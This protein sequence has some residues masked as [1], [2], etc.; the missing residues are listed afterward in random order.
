MRVQHGAGHSGLDALRA[1]LAQVIAN[2]VPGLAS[3]GPA[4]GSGPSSPPWAYS[5]AADVRADTPKGTTGRAT[6]AKTAGAGQR[7]HFGAG[8]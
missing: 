4:A 1:A 5:E 7:R 3:T 8:G 6:Q 2:P